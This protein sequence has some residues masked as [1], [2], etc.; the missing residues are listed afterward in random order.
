MTPSQAGQ[1][2]AVEERLLLG[3]WLISLLGYTSNER[4]LA[5]LSS[6]AEG[7]D[8]TGRSF[9]YSALIGRG[10]QVAVSAESLR[11]YDDNIA[12]HLGSVNHAR[13]EPFTLRYFQY[14]ALFFAEIVLD[15]LSH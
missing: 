1:G 4:M 11:A 2:T 6:V 3:R 8:A 5:D 9:M 15:R 7:F 10:E 14:L 13:R 12:R